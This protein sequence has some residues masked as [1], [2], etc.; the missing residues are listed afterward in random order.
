MTGE[1]RGRGGRGMAVEGRG[2][3]GG[4]GGEGCCRGRERCVAGEGR[5]RGG[6][7]GV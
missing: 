5:G 3:A 6:E 2:V 4:V 7:G 1:G